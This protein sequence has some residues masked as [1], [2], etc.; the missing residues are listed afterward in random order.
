MENE[1]GYKLTNRLIWNH[2]DG[3]D[4]NF[5]NFHNTF[6]FQCKNW[7]YVRKKKK[8]DCISFLSVKKL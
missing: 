1:G 8:T 4:N 7:L 5:L 6:L 2:G 3:H